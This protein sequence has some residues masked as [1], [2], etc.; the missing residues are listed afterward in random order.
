MNNWSGK[1]KARN[2]SLEISLKGNDDNADAPG[3]AV[4]FHFYI[5]ITLQWTLII[6]METK[7]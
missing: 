7:P 1:G 3:E 2:I 5:F 4:I 6:S